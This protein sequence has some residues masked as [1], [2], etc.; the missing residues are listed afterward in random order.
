MIMSSRCLHCTPE[1]V[2]SRVASLSRVRL[3]NQSSL[4]LGVAAMIDRRAF[5]VSPVGSHCRH[6][7]GI[8]KF[9]IANWEGMAVAFEIMIGSSRSVGGRDVSRT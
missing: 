7:G 2:S 5:T 8:K 4:P 1:S 3:S 6:P 9:R